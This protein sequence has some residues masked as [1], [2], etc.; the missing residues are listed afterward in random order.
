MNS[1]KK[2]NNKQKGWRWVTNWAFSFVNRKIDSVQMVALKHVKKYAWG[3]LTTAEFARNYAN[4]L[5]LM[6]TTTLIRMFFSWLICSRL[7]TGNEWF[8][9]CVSIIINVVTTIVSPFFYAIVETKKADFL[10][11][12]NKTMDHLLGI[13]P[14][15]TGLIGWDYFFE[16]RNKIIVTLSIIALIILQFVEITSRDI[17]R[18][19]I[20]ILI[21]SW[22]IDRYRQWQESIYSNGV[23]LELIEISDEPDPIVTPID[24]SA[25]SEPIKII[26]SY[27]NLLDTVDDQL[28]SDQCNLVDQNLVDQRNLVRRRK[29]RGVI[30][31]IMNWL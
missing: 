17:Q 13:R 31:Q 27:N 30:T 18:S 29:K 6:I 28:D 11:V 7:L 15:P 12:T 2:L 9:F 3:R 26:K 25:E 1:I 16:I 23:S 4:L 19:I 10:T 8:D 21:S 5:P 22:I 20:H 14:S 24:N